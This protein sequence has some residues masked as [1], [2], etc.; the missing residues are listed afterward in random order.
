MITPASSFAPLLS[1]SATV[2]P[3]GVLLL[4]LTQ[5][6][7]AWTTSNFTKY[8][9]SPKHSAPSD[10][11]LVPDVESERPCGAGDY[12]APHLPLTPPPSHLHEEKQV[13]DA[14]SQQLHKPRS[15]MQPLGE[16]TVIIGPHRFPDT[17]FF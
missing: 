12:S 1:P 2:F 17:R 10:S 4:T 11:A 3:S 9:C 8:L 14:D 15:E 13:A 6:R 7:Q 16:C 5:S